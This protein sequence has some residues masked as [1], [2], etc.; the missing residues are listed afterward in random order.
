MLPGVDCADT[1]A[2]VDR[3]TKGVDHRCHCAGSDDTVAPQILVPQ[4]QFTLQLTHERDRPGHDR[5]ADQGGIGSQPSDAV[6]EG[7]G[8][9]SGH[10][11]T[12]G[13][14]AC[15]RLARLDF[16]HSICVQS[17]ALEGSDCHSPCCTRASPSGV[18][19]P[20]SVTGTV[21]L[22]LWP[23]T[24]LV[25]RR[26]LGAHAW[27]PRPTIGRTWHGCTWAP[28]H[29]RCHVIAAVPRRWIA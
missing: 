22:G 20:I 14:T 7:R 10:R 6:G 16:Q 29:I 18:C 13:T 25:P 12:C 26:S 4:C 8:E 5:M 2:P 11:P 3:P 27:Q 28:P 23:H 21:S 24:P 15:P 17:Q 19:N 9:H 1:V